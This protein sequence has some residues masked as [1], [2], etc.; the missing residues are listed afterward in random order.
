MEMT[1]LRCGDFVRVRADSGERPG[2]D[3][4]V[5]AEPSAG[6]VGLMFNDDRYGEPQRCFYSEGVEAW[7]TSELDLASVLH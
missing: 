4:M 2:Q 5:M 1:T 6:V 7:D 3:A